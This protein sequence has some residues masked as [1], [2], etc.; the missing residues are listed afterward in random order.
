MFIYKAGVIG[1]GT[2][3]SGI[4]QTISFSGLPVILKDVDMDKVNY[5]IQLIKKIYQTRVD[6]G[7][8]SSN[9]M[10][11]KMALVTGTTSNEDFKECDIIV[12]AVYENAE[13]KK[14]V[15]TEVEKHIPENAILA[16][17]TSALSITELAA[18]VQHSER[19]VGMHFFNP[20]SVMKLVEIIPG[21]QT[22]NDV[23]QDTLTFAESLRKIPVRVKECTGFLV[24]RL[25]M[26]YLNEAAFIAQTGTATILEMDEAMRQFGMPM[27]PF[28]LMDLLGLDVCDDVANI[29]YDAYGSRM[30]P[31][32]LL[33]EMKQAK[34]WGVKSKV[35]FYTYDE[36]KTSKFPEI[37]Q[38]LSQ[39]SPQGVRP[40]SPV[41]SLLPM[42]NEAALCLEENIASPMDIDM[43]M[44]AGTGFPSEKG[45]PLHYADQL[46]L[47][48]VLQQLQLLTKQVGER[49]W[50][51]PLLKR[52]VAAGYLGTKTKKGF[53]NY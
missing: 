17:N 14:K 9:E 10:E 51:A 8:M 20:P 21:L 50:P 42:I 12:E 33:L 53:F 22:S 19:V 38:K 39:T 32:S 4:A 2:M 45:G 25:L 40:F 35:G 30:Q 28:V 1:A 11:Q 16:T 15:L 37:L 36:S 34:C 6:K 23:V 5:G 43:A 18:A 48:W 29:L 47:D 41:Q 49:F 3:G 44:M 24:N 7:K 26:P 13:V 46:G 31:S 52:M 27:G